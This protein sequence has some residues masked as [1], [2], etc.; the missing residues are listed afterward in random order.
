MAWAAGTTQHRFKAS[1]DEVFDALVAVLRDGVSMQPH[2]LRTKIK[3]LSEN[4][5][6]RRIQAKAGASAFSW[7]ENISISVSEM[8]EGSS[9]AMLDS[10]LKMGS[11]LLAG[12]RHELNF[13]A[14]LEAA[15]QRLAR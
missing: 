6:L 5:G 11:N 4:R 10:R 8:D 13:Q 1:A 7:G 3:L 14:V 15:Q 9:L 2:G 12:G